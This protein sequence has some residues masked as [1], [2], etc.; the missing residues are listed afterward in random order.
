MVFGGGTFENYLG[1]K[2]GDFFKG[3]MSFNFPVAQ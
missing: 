1:H 2:G 3:S